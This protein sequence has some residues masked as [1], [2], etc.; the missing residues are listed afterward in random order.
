MHASPDYGYAVHWRSEV[1]TDIIDAM[2]LEEFPFDIEDLTVTYR[3]RHAV[4]E[5]AIICF[6]PESQLIQESTTEDSNPLVGRPNEQDQKDLLRG[7]MKNSS[8]KLESSAEG[9]R[10]VDMTHANVT[11]PDYLLVIT[12]GVS[13]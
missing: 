10:F 9:M 1:K 12:G 5:V 13:R 4:H 2:D 3:L 6:P 11:L 7:I 8:L